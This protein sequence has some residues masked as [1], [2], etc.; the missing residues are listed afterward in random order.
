MTAAM[1]TV[2]EN[3]LPGRGSRFFS[4]KAFKEDNW[5]GDESLF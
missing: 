4:K 3:A 5:S 1:Q 2:G